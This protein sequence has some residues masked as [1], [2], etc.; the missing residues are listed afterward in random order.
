MHDERRYK[1]LIQQGNGQV[2][3]R[4]ISHAMFLDGIQNGGLR[5][6]GNDR[7]K[8]LNFASESVLTEDMVTCGGQ[9][10]CE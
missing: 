4:Y 10:G 3:V 5:Y 6:F 1:I 9:F 2:W 7:Q 8:I